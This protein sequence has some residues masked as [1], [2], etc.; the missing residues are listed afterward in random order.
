MVTA[1]AAATSRH[2]GPGAIAITDSFYYDG[3]I[4]GHVKLARPSAVMGGWPRKRLF[5]QSM[6]TNVS[7]ASPISPR[8]L[9]REASSIRHLLIAASIAIAWMILLCSIFDPK[10]E[11][12]DDVAMSMVAHGYGIADYG[13]DH[14]FFSN[15]LWGAIV[16]SLPSVDGIL[17]YSIATLLSLALAGAATVYFLL[18]LGVRPMVATLVLTIVFTRPILFPQFTET[19]GLLGIAAA[20]GLQAFCRRR[21]V[22]DLVAACCLAFFAY[23]IRDLELALVV[24]VALPLLP[25]GKLAASR[26]ARLAAALLLICVAGAAIADARA[27]LP[28]EWQTFRQQ[29]L[30]RAPLTDFG[31]ATFILE[32]PDLMQRHGLSRNDIRLVSNWFFIDPQLSNPELLRSLI[33]EIPAQMILERNLASSLDALLAIP[34]SPSLRTLTYISIALLM[35]LL[36]PR[37][38]AVW[39]LFFAAIFAFASVGRPPPARVC[40]PLLG[41]LIFAAVSMQPQL[42]RWRDLALTAALLAGAVSNAWHLIGEAT[43]SDRAI[44]LARLQKFSSPESTFVWGDALPFEAVFPVFTRVDDV[45]S[46]RIY[47]L[48]VLTLAPFSV[49]TADEAAHRGFLVRLR[50]EAGIP[51]I[52]APEQQSLLNTY[53]VEH[54]GTPLRTQIKTKGE[55]WS[56]VNASC[57]SAAK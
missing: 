39:A 24:A 23:L 14:L 32:R 52:A 48:G 29:N 15:V 42:P 49:P 40:F 38:F 12:N 45:R 3:A 55:L 19:A 9:D 26:S 56:V 30:A 33:R 21:S 31:S 51:L 27:Y 22:Y 6:N 5:L 7:T 46:T 10:W 16:R 43:A 57:A 18:R 4:D 54:L 11:T 41:L 25:W 34:Q 44:A 37:L 1:S 36:R 47:A 35:I 28:P 8:A 13:S 50:T 17:G 20:L 2:R 53:C